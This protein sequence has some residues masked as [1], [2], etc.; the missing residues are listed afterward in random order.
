MESDN[1]EVQLRIVI[2]KDTEIEV[3]PETIVA[4]KPVSPGLIVIYRKNRDINKTI[5]AFIT[6]VVSIIIIL[7][8]VLSH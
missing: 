8:V 7:V 2:P 3:G 6:F 1:S 5:C 4:P